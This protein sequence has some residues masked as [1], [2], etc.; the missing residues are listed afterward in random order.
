MLTRLTPPPTEPL[1]L[2]DLKIYLKIDCADDD[3]FLESLISTARFY[4]ENQLHTAFGVSDYKLTLCQPPLKLKLPVSPVQSVAAVNIKDENGQYIPL[5]SL[6]YSLCE[7]TLT[8]KLEQSEVEILF[9]AGHLTPPIPLLLALKMLAAHWYDNRGVIN[10][11]AGLSQL[12][13]GL[14]A[15][16]ASNK[17]VRLI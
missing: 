16:L 12:P 15:L 5:D 17:K 11:T 4:L 3:V 2:A 13:M 10:D 7:E 1:S 14:N 8:F 6:L 9:S